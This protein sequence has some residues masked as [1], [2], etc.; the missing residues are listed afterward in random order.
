MGKIMSSQQVH[1]R[2]GR[3]QIQCLHADE[4]LKK[5][6]KRPRQV[7]TLKDIAAAGEAGVKTRSHQALRQWP[8]LSEPASPKLRNR[9]YLSYSQSFMGMKGMTGATF[10]VDGEPQ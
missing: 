10:E 1:G 9:P 5:K 2:K 8:H 4:K 6:T 7:K 3:N